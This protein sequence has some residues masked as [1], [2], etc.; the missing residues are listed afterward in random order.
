MKAIGILKEEHRAIEYLLGA[1]EFQAARLPG[2]APIRIEF[3]LDAAVFLREFVEDRH[4][5][6][7][8]D[9]ILVALVD[10]GLVRDGGPIAEVLAAHA[11]SQ[12]LVREIEKQARIVLGGGASARTELA[13]D[14]VEYVTLLT[15]HIH[16]EDEKV[17]PL[18]DT[19][20]PMGIQDELD[21]YFDRIESAYVEAGLHDKYYGLAEKLAIEAAS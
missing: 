11:K 17:F 12:E 5:R 4:Q 9:T 6:K 20:I 10:A 2:D 16:Q 18:A 8:E 1:L 3:F 14:A 21:A 15:Q 19:M 13:R 7:E